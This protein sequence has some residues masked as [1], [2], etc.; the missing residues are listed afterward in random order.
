MKSKTFFVSASPTARGEKKG[1]DVAVDA[2][3]APFLAA[4]PGIKIEGYTLA[5]DITVGG[6]N[7]ALVSVIYS[8]PAKK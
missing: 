5:G 8:E 2:A 7:R 6:F 3:L 1:L 4:N